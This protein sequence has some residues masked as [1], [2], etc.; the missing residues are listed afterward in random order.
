[1]KTW[2]GPDLFTAI[3]GLVAALFLG[4]ALNGCTNAVNM[5]SPLRVIRQLSELQTMGKFSDAG[6]ILYATEALDSWEGSSTTNEIIALI[7][8]GGIGGLGTGALASPPMAQGA[9]IGANSILMLLNL[10]RPVERSGLY[11]QGAGLVRGS[12][13]DY[14]QALM[15]EGYCTVPINRVTISGAI[16]FAETNAAIT[17]V[18]NRKQ[19][20]IDLGSRSVQ[21]LQ[22]SRARRS[23]ISSNTR[24]PEQCK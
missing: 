13:G 23:L 2:I 1:M 6:I 21:Q 8:A 20:I 10:W 19:G 15:L 3:L 22:A 4:M 9:L 16:L 17:E 5:P 11:V 24:I 7:G 18:E 14:L 12:L